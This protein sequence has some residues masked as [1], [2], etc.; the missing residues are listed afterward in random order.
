MSYV[1]EWHINYLDTAPQVESLERVVKSCQWSIRGYDS[2]DSSISSSNFGYCN[3]GEPDSESFVAY[4]DLT[5]Q[6]ILNW[7]WANGVD[8]DGIEQGLATSMD[9]QRNPPTVILPNPW[10]QQVNTPQG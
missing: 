6:D 9:G 5:E 3:F 4:A 8:R 10:S 7:I 1:F 2:E